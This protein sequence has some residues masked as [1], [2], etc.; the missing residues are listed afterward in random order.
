MN[1][2]KGFMTLKKKLTLA[3]ITAASDLTLPF[4][5]LYDASDYAIVVVLG[6]REK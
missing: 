3:L 2:I 5:I 4:E 1:V 6:Q